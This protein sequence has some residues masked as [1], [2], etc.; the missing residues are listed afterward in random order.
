MKKMRYG[1]I[2]LF[3]ICFCTGIIHAAGILTPKNANHQALRI[4][5]HHVDVTINNGFAMTE[6]SQ[7]FC[8]PNPMTV[9][10]VYSFPVPESASLSEV[11]IYLDEKEIHGEV[12]RKDQAR[13]IYEEEKSSGKDA[14]LSEKK[15][16]YTFDFSISQIPASGNVRIR[17]RYYQPLRIDLGIGRYV[18]PLQNGGTDDAAEGFWNTNDRVEKLFSVNLELNTACPVSQVRVPGFERE[19]VI[20]KKDD[21]HYEVRLEKQSTNLNNDF[22]FYYKLAENLPGRVEMI[23]YR[24]AE[25]R[26]GSFM[27]VVTPGLDLQ[28]VKNGADYTFVLDTS[29]SMESKLSTLIAGIRK[30]L[31][32]MKPEDRFRIISFNSVASDITGGFVSAEREHVLAWCDEVSKLRAGNSTNIYAALELA[33]TSLD[34]DRISSVILVTDGVTNQGILDHASFEALLKKNDVRMFGFLMGNSGNWPLMKTICEITGGYLGS[35][36]NDD[37]IIGQILLAKSKILR[38]SLHHAE[39]SVSGVRV[40]DSTDSNMGK[41]YQGDQL[42][43]FGKYEKGGRAVVSLKGNLTGKDKEYTTTFDFPEKDTRFPEVERLWAMNRIEYL[44]RQTRLGKIPQGESD[45]AISDLGVKYQLV[46]D[47]TSMIVLSNDAFSKRGIRRNNQERIIR[48]RKE[49]SSRRAVAFNPGK[50]Y[51]VAGNQ[52]VPVN[53]ARSVSNPYRVD[54]SRPMFQDNAP[55]S[56]SGGGAFDFFGAVLALS[57]IGMAGFLGN[58][59][60]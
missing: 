34:S 16:F 48:E 8:N 21:T 6:V 3:M 53:A 33:L 51:Q 37:D 60:G 18:Y 28:P 13:Q 47:E 57:M 54:S 40:F 35:V 45:T 27:M 10:A 46:T 17:F 50:T 52:P 24:E 56:R 12:V 11:A 59:E 55:S 2:S 5:S 30:V 7:T 26:P 58:Q 25:D 29:G 23:A 14:G 1:F 9:E 49:Q 15:E 39:L 22:V 20:S 38:E 42:V 43:I 19:A 4:D 44:Q 32:T 36:S 31:G 41:V